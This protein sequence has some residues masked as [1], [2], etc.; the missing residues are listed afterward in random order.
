M[1]VAETYATAASPETLDLLLTRRSVVA[2]NLG[3]PG[4]DAETLRKIIAAGLRV[5]DHGKL[6]PWRVQVLLAEG[7]AALGDV[8]AS[9]Y[10]AD[11]PDAEERM[12]EAERQRPQRSP[13]LLVVT[14]RVDPHHPKIP[15]IEQRLSGGALCQ[16]I[17]VAAHASGFAAQWLTE[18]PA[19]H[20]SVVGNARLAFNVL[21]SRDADTARRLVLEKDRMRDMEKESSQRHFHRLR[22]GTVKSLE[23]STIHLDTIRDLKQINSLLASIA[24]PVLEEQGLLRDSRLRA[25]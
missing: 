19:F 13:V 3:A 18:W 6:G 24:Y 16:N 25:G 5:P 9:V 17:L 10:R 2:K 22:D 12:V 21:V 23:T 20:A 1:S 4:P 14:A 7:Q 11:N 15:E 8:L